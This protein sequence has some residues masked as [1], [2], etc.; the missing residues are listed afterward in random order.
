MGQV[1]RGYAGGSIFF[2]DGRVRDD[3]TRVRAYARL[4]ASIGIN[5][6]AHQQRQRA[7]GRGPPAHRPPARRRR[8]ADVFRPYGIRSTCR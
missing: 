3:L 4:L 1:E 2:R 8:L 6:V 7:R 5:A